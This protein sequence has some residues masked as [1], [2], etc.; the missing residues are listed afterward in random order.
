[1]V[2]FGFDGVGWLGGWGFLGEV[3]CFLY[4]T[5]VL[6]ACISMRGYEITWNWI[7]DSCECLCGC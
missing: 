1:M 3:F 7:T 5:G 4:C 6:P 2:C